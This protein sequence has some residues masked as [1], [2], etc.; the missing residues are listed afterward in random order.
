[1]AR[2]GPRM[3]GLQTLALHPSGVH[4]RVKGHEPTREICTVAQSKGTGLL[5]RW[6]QFAEVS[7]WLWQG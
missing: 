1:M 2:T 5:F 3:S 6:Q 7:V 4:P